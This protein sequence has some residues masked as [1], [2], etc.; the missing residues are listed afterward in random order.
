MHHVRK[1]YACPA[2]ERNGDN[3][4]MET[5]TKP[6]TAI[7]KGL[8]GPGLLAYIATCKFS[9]Y[10]PFYRIEDIFARQGFEIRRP[11]AESFRSL[12]WAVYIIDTASP[13]SRRCFAQHT[14]DPA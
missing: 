13:C 9:E 10:L 2:C 3:P 1:K 6:E 7:E 8:A 5:A 12:D 4:R 14:T 11:I